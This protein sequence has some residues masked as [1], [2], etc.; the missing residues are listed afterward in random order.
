M[1]LTAPNGS[2]ITVD[3]KKILEMG[4]HV[5]GGSFVKVGAHRYIVTEQIEEI[6]AQ[7]DG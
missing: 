3:R 6:L 5:D 7:H 2:V 1:K 4:P